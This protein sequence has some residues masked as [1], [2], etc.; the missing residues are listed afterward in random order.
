[1]NYNKE[2]ISV[3]DDGTKKAITSERIKFKQAKHKILSKRK[4]KK[5][6]PAE[7]QST[8]KI[9]IIQKYISRTANLSILFILT[10]NE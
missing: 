8:K 9:T 6:T 3:I 7:I 4:H 1:M 5:F 2:G 10:Y